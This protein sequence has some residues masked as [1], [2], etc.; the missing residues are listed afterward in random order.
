MIKIIA[1][2]GKK[3]SGKTTAVEELSH[4]LWE[5]TGRCVDEVA[6]ADR[7]KS[8]VMDYFIVPDGGADDP[9]RFNEE[10][11]KQ[12]KHSCGLTIREILQKVGTDWFRN[13]W[14]DIWVKNYKIE[15][16]DFDGGIERDIILT[17][18]VRF[19]NEVKCIQDLGGHVIRLLRNPHNDQHESETALDDIE[20]YSQALQDDP[21]APFTKDIITDITFNAVIDNRE[22][23]IPEQSDAVWKLV[24]ER[25]LL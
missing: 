13:I 5:E 11:Y 3:Q 10:K 7:L 14:P 22:M 18:D 9:P 8:L 2:S 20:W 1:F 23:S 25:K 16:T 4:R 19:P 21:N 12:I 24:N 17:G 15:V 6:F